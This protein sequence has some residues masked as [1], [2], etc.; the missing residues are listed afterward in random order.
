MGFII[1]DLIIFK[2]VRVIPNTATSDLLDNPKLT[3]F[4]MMLD[5]YLFPVSP[6]GYADFTVF[7][8]VR[9]RLLLFLLFSGFNQTVNLN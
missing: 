5:P 7:V 8:T 4:E 2:V 9:V 1:E 6:E 3:R